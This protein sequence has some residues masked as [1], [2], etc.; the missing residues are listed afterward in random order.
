MTD[1]D[2]QELADGLDEMREV[3]RAMVSGLVA[4]GFSEQQ[5]RD[6][7]TSVFTR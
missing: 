1:L 7:A 2:Y 6:I 3:L 4:D 5:A